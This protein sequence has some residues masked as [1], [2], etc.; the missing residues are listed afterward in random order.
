MSVIPL[1]L[2]APDD[3]RDRAVRL[4]TFLREY[5]Q[6][7]ASTALT[8]DSYDEVIWLADVPGLPGCVCAAVE[9]TRDGEVWLEVRKPRLVP[10]PRPP[11]VLRPWLERWDDSAVETPALR[12]SI[13]AEPAEPALG[14]ELAPP[15]VLADRPDV[16]AAYDEYLAGEWRPW[17]LRDRPLQRAQRIYT[18][19]FRL[20]QSQQRLGEAYEVVMGIGLL[21]WRTPS[22]NAV[23]RHLIVAQTDVRFDA[24]RGVISVTAAAD[25]ARPALEQDMLEPGERPPRSVLDEIT[26]DLAAVGDDVFADPAVA[27]AARRWAHGASASG[28]FDD[29]LRPPRDAGADPAVHLAPAVIL[30][31][32]SDRSIVQSLTSISEQLRDGVAIP[33]G[34]RR[35]VDLAEPE[36]AVENLLPEPAVVE[37]DDEVL[38]PLPAND[39]Q[40]DIV[41]RLRDRPG[42]LVQGPPGTGKSHTIAN[43]VAHL[44]A[45]G[46]RVLVTSHTARALEVLRDRIP[47]D[48]REL[49]VV[50]LG[51]DA[52]GRE[53]LQ[54]SVH[55]ISERYASWDGR[56]SRERVARHRRELET[57]RAA[58]AELRG[59]FRELRE[60]D[61][62]R[63]MQVYGG[64]E[65]TAQE[66]ARQLRARALDLGWIPDRVELAA[67]APLDDAEAVALLELLRSIDALEEAELDLLATDVA[68]LPTPEAFA[69]LV[70]AEREAADQRAELTG[71]PDPALAAAPA[72]ALQEL[73]SAI[74]AL[75]RRRAGL[76]RRAEG[77]V[78]DAAGQ[79]T[80]GMA[81]RWRELERMTRE[82]LDAV[83]PFATDAGATEV[84]GVDGRDLATVQAD[85]TALRQ[86]LEA[87]GSLG[88]G[89]IRPE[90]VK[91][92]RYLIEGTRVDGAPCRDGTTL[93]RL[94]GWAYVHDR[95]NRLD[96]AWTPLRQ[97]S[98]GG[99]A[100]RC[101]EYADVAATLQDVLRLE[102]AIADAVG[103]A[104]AVPGLAVPAWEDD[105]GLSELL[106]AIDGGGRERRLQAAR[107]QLDDVLAATGSGLPAER[108]AR[109]AVADRDALAY[110]AQRA[111]LDR[112]ADRREALLRRRDLAERLRAGAPRLAARLAATVPDP[113]WDA[114]F[115]AFTAAWDWARADAW[116]VAQ[117]DPTLTARLERDLDDARQRIERATRQL[118]AELAWA[119]C[120]NR[121]SERERAHLQTWEEAVRK[122]GKGTGKHA[123]RWRKQARDAMQ[124]CR[125]A[126]PAWIMPIFK[127]AETVD[128]TPEAFDVVIVDE[129]SQS[130]PEALFLQFLARHVIVVGDDQQISPDNVGVDRDKVQFLNSQYLH[131]V[132][133]AMHYDADT[134]YF[135]HA[136][137]RY[138]DRL[139]LQEH[140]RCMPE[141]IQF[142]NALC[143]RDRPLVPLRQFG[144]DRLRP[145]IQVRRVHDGVYRDDQVNEAEAVA[146]VDQIVA[147]LEDPDYAGRTMGVISLVGSEQAKLISRLLT[148]RLDPAEIDRRRL[149]CG[150]AYAFQGDERDVMFLSL[151]QAPRA[152]RQ[153]YAGTHDRD[154]RRFNVAAS[155]ARDQLWLFHTATLDDLHP[156]GV[157]HR[158]LHYCLQPSVE[159]VPARGLAVETWRRRVAE[160]APGEAVPHPFDSWLELDVFLRLVD[161]G[162]RVIPQHDIAGFRVDLLVEGRNGRLA[163]EC[164]GDQWRGAN[165]FEVELARQRM[166]E[167]CGLPFARVRG[168]SFYR[169]PDAALEPLWAALKQYDIRPTA[170]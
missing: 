106:G 34:V 160:R 35:L 125:S 32:R 74:V 156:A 55:G 53:E 108:A 100:L 142:S 56:R 158:L 83:R 46:R 118:A 11:E 28:A 169:D 62:Q 117:A 107:D 23:R 42:V 76:V 161:R 98:A 18:D 104:A 33:E 26:A 30:R 90:P 7:R 13:P 140:F 114:K 79:V 109:A 49:A 73:A 60:R 6:L 58:E 147:C 44:L 29:S 166:L 69:A 136:A 22:G 39:T 123:A 66:I 132:P 4:F 157:A 148:Q 143:Y 25:G 141:I 99:A 119:H 77:W 116:L 40:L 14:E 145:A 88:F 81:G 170:R 20:H 115:A 84:T 10:A 86:H 152:G 131:D 154:R 63:H 138:G 129:A 9:P 101:A 65:G 5:T 57:A 91:R 61:T 68:A 112:L 50:V 153:L 43:L 113:V 24:D 78:A 163:V 165:E 54:A 80:A 21:A 19:L 133:L 72:E 159:P 8:T 75:R 36:V 164:D 31:R 92:A 144:S 130:G 41:R 95:L 124:G 151:V 111:N 2:A 94:A 135:T 89:P 110:T 149:L 137:I 15:Q 17:A 70:A 120:L 82:T 45:H 126:I 67:E 96:R 52:R 48:V 27:S 127:V 38:F 162:Y 128:M 12:E 139:V 121:L 51:N 155:R 3:V 105:A 134:S 97:A 87:G 93:A 16:R 146:I 150:D 85:A 71:P 103:A 102:D 59:R 167:R 47:P 1:P 168:A 37:P 122:I 64:Y